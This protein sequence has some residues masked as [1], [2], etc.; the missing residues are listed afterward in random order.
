[1][2]D[3]VFEGSYVV[4]TSAGMCGLWQPEHFAQVVDEDA[5]EDDVSED[6]ALETHIRLGAFVPLNIGGGGSFQVTIREGG[7]TALEGRYTLVLSEPY[8]LVSR[9]AIEVGGLENVGPYLGGAQEAPIAAGR[10]LVR[11]R[12]IDWKADPAS[13]GPDGGPTA[14]ALPDFLVE[15]YPVPDEATSFRSSV[16]TFERPE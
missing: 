8:L 2:S 6:D 9:G 15:I 16:H 1:M 4:S 12:L 7:P 11:V 14:S 3:P 13:V 5:W 10:Y